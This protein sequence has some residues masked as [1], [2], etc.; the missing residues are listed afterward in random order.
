MRQYTTD[1]NDIFRGTASYPLEN[2]PKD[3]RWVLIGD[4]YPWAAA[5]RAYNKRLRNQKVGAGNKPARAVIGA[6]IIKHTMCLSDEETMQAIVENPYMQYLCG[7]KFYSTEPLFTPE[8]LSIVRKRVDEEFYN[9]MTLMLQKCLSEKGDTKDDDSYIDEDG[10]LHK[11]ITKND[12]TCSDAEMRYPTDVNLLED[13]SRVLERVMQ[14]ICKRSRIQMPH[15]HRGDA[16]SAFILYIKYRNSKGGRKKSAYSTK[17]TKARLLHFLSL[18]YQAFIDLIGKLPID[19]IGQILNRRDIRELCALK[20]MFDQQKEM[21]D[22]NLHACA[23]RIVSIF[24]PH[25]RPIVRGKERS[26]VEFGAKIGVSVVN[27]MTYIDH[28]SWDAYNESSDL[29]MQ[30][31]NYKERFGYYPSQVQADKIYLNKENRKLLEQ[32][33]I[34]CHC[35]PL[36][37]PPKITDSSEKDARRR[38]SAER[39]EVEGTFGTGKRVYRANNIRA[40]LPETARSWIAAC[41]FAKNLMKFLREFHCLLREKFGLLFVKRRKIHAEWPNALAYVNSVVAAA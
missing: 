35:R 3:N 15:T 18:D 32:L 26:K 4:K 27:G 39:N 41:Y 10:N 6:L 5:E 24:Q 29:K 9:E 36:G 33:H 28:I 19:D 16:R 14:K 2:L 17:K 31:E 21:F 37:R 11:G 20:K 25:V 1:I 40:K 23:D 30:I 8:L 12:A 38:A 34:K 13:G 7:R 22:N